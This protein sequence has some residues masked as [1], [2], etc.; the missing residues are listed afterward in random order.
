MT[1]NAN[2]ANDIINVSTRNPVEPALWRVFRV[3]R[4]EE[5]RQGTIVTEHNVARGGDWTERALENS[6]RRDGGAHDDITVTHVANIMVSG[7][8]SVFDQERAVMGI[9]D[10]LV[11]EGRMEADSTATIAT[12]LEREDGEDG[13]D[14]T[15]AAAA[16][17]IPTVDISGGAEATETMEL[18][19]SMDGDGYAASAAD[20]FPQDNMRLVARIVAPAG[21]NRETACVRAESEYHMRH[22]LTR[23]AAAEALGVSPNRIT[24]MISAGQLH[25]AATIRNADRRHIILLHPVEVAALTDRRPGRP[26]K[27]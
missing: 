10:R 26:R 5:T 15:T 27:A 14:T 7:N 9:V 23:A 1:A 18:F 12:A 8:R 2:A 3:R 4:V 20:C 17:G 6:L 19:R 11:E 13:R 21:M 25:V 16:D 22:C 24:N